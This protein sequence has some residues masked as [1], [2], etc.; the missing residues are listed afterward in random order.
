MRISDWSSDVCSS[1]LRRRWVDIRPRRVG[2]RPPQRCNLH[3]SACRPVSN[4]TRHRWSFRRVSRSRRLRAVGGQSE[5]RLFLVPRK[6]YEIIDTWHTFGRPR[7]AVDGGHAPLPP[8][9]E[10]HTYELQSLKRISSAV[11]CLKKK[12]R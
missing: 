10:E 6:D 2:W 1:D 7:D 11:F 8:R 3:T 9:P 4:R 12:I 5:M